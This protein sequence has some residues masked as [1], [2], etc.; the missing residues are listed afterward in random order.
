M[1]SSTQG[2]PAR[3]LCAEGRSLPDQQLLTAE[4]MGTHHKR[5]ANTQTWGCAYR[6]QVTDSWAVTGEEKC[7][8][9]LCK[10]CDLYILIDDRITELFWL[11]EPLKVICLVPAP[12]PWAGT[13]ACPSNKALNV[14]RHGKTLGNMF[15]A[16]TTLS[17]KKLLAYIQKKSTL[18][19]F[20]T[21]MS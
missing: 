16:F 3:P 1:S 2:L 7:Q 10:A 19:Q 14:S 11:K 12:L 13:P 5:W 8:R 21:I 18:P 6:T 15:C 9:G 4:E 17:A 20:K